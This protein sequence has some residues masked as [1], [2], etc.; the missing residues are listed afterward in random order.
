VVTLNPPSVDVDVVSPAPADNVLDEGYLNITT[1][2]PPL[3]PFPLELPPAPPP[4]RKS[5]PSPPLP[6]P[7]A[8]PPPPVPPLL[9]VSL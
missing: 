4:P 3:P 8:V 2:D 1:P 7:G 6:L 9:L 5:V